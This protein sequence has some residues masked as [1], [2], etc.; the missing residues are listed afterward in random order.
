MKGFW[1]FFEITFHLIIYFIT[2]NVFLSLTYMIYMIEYYFLEKLKLPW[3]SN[4]NSICH[5]VD[6][7]VT[8]TITYKKI[9]LIHK[10][11]LI[12]FYQ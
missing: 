6:T 10:N 12:G 5:L 3:L 8:Y 1:E 4:I 9:R 2:E 7:Y 11:S